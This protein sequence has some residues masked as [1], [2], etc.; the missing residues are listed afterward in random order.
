[1]TI[2]GLEPELQKLM[3]KSKK[4]KKMIESRFEIILA[5]KSE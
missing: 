4:D 2:K 5:Q 3:D 1:M